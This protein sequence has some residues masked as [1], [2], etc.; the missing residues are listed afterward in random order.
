MDLLSLFVE[1][2]VA[3]HENSS[4]STP[5]QLESQEESSD[6]VKSCVDAL[7]EIS[8]CHV[9]EGEGEDKLYPSHKDRL[10][11]LD[12]LENYHTYAME[13]KQAALSA[14]TWLN[15][16]GRTGKSA[17]IGELCLPNSSEF[18]SEEMMRQMDID[19]LRPL[20]QAT[21]SQ[22]VEK[23]DMN[24][25]LDRELSVCRAEI[26]RLKTLSRN[27]VSRYKCFKTSDLFL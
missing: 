14:S 13:M 15:A 19:E 18:I 5:D 7:R 1:R 20:I 24:D 17:S 11:V 16:I 9:G 4:A 21:H 6:D 12:S 10:K 8:K 3:F 2:S 25:R 23:N 27:E 26:G 22:L